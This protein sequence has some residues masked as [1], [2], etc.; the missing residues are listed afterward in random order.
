MPNQKDNIIE[1]IYNEQD[2]YKNI[3]K[4]Q[5]SMLSN[6]I[7]YSLHFEQHKI[8]TD[9]PNKKSFQKNNRL[10]PYTYIGIPLEQLIP[11]LFSLVTDQG[12]CRYLQKLLEIN[13]L[14]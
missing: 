13:P 6:T 2:K 8:N 14:N 1:K 4:L 10:N 11:N 9:F 12:G 5:Y 7:T 3:D